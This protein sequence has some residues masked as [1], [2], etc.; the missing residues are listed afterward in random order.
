MLFPN[1]DYLEATEQR[2]RAKYWEFDETLKYDLIPGELTPEGTPR[3]IGNSW[4]EGEVVWDGT[5]GPIQPFMEMVAEVSTSIPTKSGTLFVKT[6]KTPVTVHVRL[7]D[8]NSL[9]GDSE[10]L[11]RGQGTTRKMGVIHGWGTEEDYGHRRG[12]Q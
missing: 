6:T 11:N 9:L 1:G 8:T 4:T 3:V 5:S 7:A 12:G 2:T 10:A